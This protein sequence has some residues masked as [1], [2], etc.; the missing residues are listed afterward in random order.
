MLSVI[1]TLRDLGM[2]TSKISYGTVNDRTNILCQYVCLLKLH[3]TSEFSI[4]K[5]P[6]FDFQ[7]CY[8]ESGH[9]MHTTPIRPELEYEKNIIF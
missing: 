2:G 5:S 1:N 4:E 6:Y 3:Q 7:G 8:K 9:V